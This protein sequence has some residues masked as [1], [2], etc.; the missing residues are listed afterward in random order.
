MLHDFL[1]FSLGVLDCIVP[2]LVWFERSLHF[3]QVSGQSCP[4]PLKL[5]TSQAVES[6]WIG[7][8]GSGANGLKL[9]IDTAK[10]IVTYGL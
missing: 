1:P 7:T 8:G 4:R 10:V 3:A 9:S 5:M 6:T 2:I